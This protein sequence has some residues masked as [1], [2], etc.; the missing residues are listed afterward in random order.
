MRSFPDQP[1]FGLPRSP[2]G[3]RTIVSADAVVAIAPVDTI[4]ALVTESE[5]FRHRPDYIV[6]RFVNIGGTDCTEI[7]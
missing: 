7:G 4:V 6:F 5:S 1:G 2:P 3:N